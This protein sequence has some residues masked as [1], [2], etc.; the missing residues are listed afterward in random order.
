M[1]GDLQ[2]AELAAFKREELEAAIRTRVQTVHIG[3]DR[4]LARVLG[5]PKMFLSA[6]DLGLSCHLM[7][8]GF[9]ESW[10]TLF[11]ARYV[12]PGMTVF[13]VGANFGYYTV[14]FA[15]G[16]GPLGRVIAIEPVPATAA[17]LNDT[18]ELN[19]FSGF[20]RVVTAAATAGSSREVHLFV[21]QREPKNSA[22]IGEPRDG[23]IVVPSCT[24]DELAAELDR[25][26]LVK[27]DVEGAE[28][29][30]ILGM[31]ETIKRCRP[32][33]LLEYNAARYADP[34][35]F[36]GALLATY[37]SVSSIG[38]D[39]VPVSVSPDTI[40]TTRFGEDWLLFF[41]RSSD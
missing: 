15:A 32:S 41:S 22:I 19:G 35:G 8:D 20:T 2:Y 21:P 5:G 6:T 14:L 40:V 23:S 12:K 34:R 36:L 30:V 1:H 27:I 17:L 29:D 7:L 25:V 4:V 33:V 37:G 38:W 16:V 9:W 18:V 24:I 11:F 31:S 28:I 3:H 13:D 10:L 26:D 39:G